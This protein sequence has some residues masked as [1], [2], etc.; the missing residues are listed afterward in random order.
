M[1]KHTSTSVFSIPKFITD[2]YTVLSCMKANSHRRV[3]LLRDISSGEKVVLKCGKGSNGDLL[4][5]EYSIA[6]ELDGKCA[7][8]PQC[9]EYFFEGD[10]HY[11]IREYAE[12]KTAAELISEQGALPEKE[13][14]RITAALCEGISVLHSQQ[15]PIICRDIN[16]DNVLL[17]DNGDVKLIDIDAARYYDKSSSSDTS[18]IGTKE[19]AAPEQFGYV[20]TTERTDIYVLGMLLLYLATAAY[21]RRAPLPAPIKRIIHKC[22]AFDPEKRYPTVMVLHKALTKNSRKLLLPAAAAILL[23]CGIVGAIYLLQQNESIIADEPAH[24]SGSDASES[25][26]DEEAIFI[27]PDIE[28]AVRQQLAKTK[29][30][31]IYLSELKEVHTLILCGELTFSTWEEFDYYRQQCIDSYA[32]LPNATEPLP[33]DDLSMLTELE[34]LVLN[35]QGL[36][37]LPPLSPSIRYLSIMDN[38]L[39]E[40][41]GIEVCAE[42]D[43][44]HLSGNYNLTDISP[45]AK[46][47]KLRV[48]NLSCCVSLENVDAITSLPLELLHINYTDVKHIS[49]LSQLTKLKELLFT[50]LD[51]DTLSQISSLKTL[52][53]IEICG[54]CTAITDISVFMGLDDLYAL[55]IGDCSNFKSIEGISQLESLTNFSLINTAV[56]E[57]PHEIADTHLIT[58]NLRGCD[59]ADFSTLANIEELTAL[60]VDEKHYEAASR[61]FNGRNI[62]IMS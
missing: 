5:Q 35:K 61:I 24:T 23:C 50:D 42:L 62:T 14:R 34:Y 17:C 28:N 19:M 6:Q 59:I 26:T 12:G 56:S 49:S 46:L 45:L 3:Y 47:E 38:E 29:N 7:M 13:C 48:L 39:A 18:C 22:T 57:L 31:P 15:P 32:A 4:F 53:F 55:T 30:E 58:V 60:Y 27:S 8:L 52:E 10:T 2:R 21:D 41:S 16:P 20:Q 25:I 36:T 40:L 51:S 11:Y 33:V 9:K 44:L 54:D 1:G 43:T 37:Q